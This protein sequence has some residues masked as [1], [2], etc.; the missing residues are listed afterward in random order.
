MTFEQV[1]NLYLAVQN[2]YAELPADKYESQA[3]KV[4]NAN[5]Y[6]A[7]ENSDFVE[8]EFYDHCELEGLFD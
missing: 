1:L 7:L 2:A 3:T 8:S 6:Y 4:A 5:F